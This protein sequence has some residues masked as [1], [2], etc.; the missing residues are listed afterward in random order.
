MKILQD[1][2]AAEKIFPKRSTC[3]VSTLGDGKIIA[4]DAFIFSHDIQAYVP[5]EIE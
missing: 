1:S 4:G 2:S 3:E 5:E